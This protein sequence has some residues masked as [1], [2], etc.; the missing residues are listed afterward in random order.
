MN[1]DA[2]VLKRFSSVLNL[3]QCVQWSSPDTVVWNATLV[4]VGHL[5]CLDDWSAVFETDRAF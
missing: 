2:D 3:V 4:L 1:G 5:I